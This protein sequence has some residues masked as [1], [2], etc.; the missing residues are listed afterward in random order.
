MYK[1]V[2]MFLHR[3]RRGEAWNRTS[4]RTIRKGLTL[5][6]AQKHCA[7]PETSL[8][9]CKRDRYKGKYKHWFDGYDQCVE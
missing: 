9:T 6:E 7:K 4:S 2:R 8:H 3:R 1:I 5:K